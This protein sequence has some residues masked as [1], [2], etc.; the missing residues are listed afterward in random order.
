MKI[1]TLIW[2]KSFGGNVGRVYSSKIYAIEVSDDLL[3]Y[4]NEA[5][6]LSKIHSARYK[7]HDSDDH[8]G[9]FSQTYNITKRRM[10]SYGDGLIH[11]DAT[12]ISYEVLGVTKHRNPLGEAGDIFATSSAMIGITKKLGGYYLART[13]PAH[14]MEVGSVV[15]ALS[16]IRKVISQDS[17]PDALAGTSTA[18]HIYKVRKVILGSDTDGADI[19]SVVRAI[20]KTSRYIN[21]FIAVGMDAVSVVERLTKHRNP[22]AQ[23]DEHADI[24]SIVTALFKRSGKGFVSG[25]ASDHFEHSSV[26]SAIR[27]TSPFVHGSDAD[28]SDAF[29][30][31]AEIRK[32]RKVL[33]GADAG[34]VEV[35]SYVRSILKNSHIIKS[36]LQSALDSM[37]VALDVRKVRRSID[38]L[39]PPANV[40]IGIAKFF[41]PT[42]ADFGVEWDAMGSPSPE[43]QDVMKPPVFISADVAW[44]SRLHPPADI[45]TSIARL[46]KPTRVS[47]EIIWQAE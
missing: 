13:L 33:D 4:E 32:T 10:A 7:E 45:D 17:S 38:G 2:L 29:S 8:L 11:D 6:L 18:T 31:V 9:S 25:R 20:T 34:A 30:L 12:G 22:A 40:G 39:E 35:G 47:T 3:G 42:Q 26:V 19:G 24:S 36:D 44:D 46:F 27:K 16:K 21:G 15:A 5:A 41:K 23:I 1:S 14:E 28:G 37:S 43:V